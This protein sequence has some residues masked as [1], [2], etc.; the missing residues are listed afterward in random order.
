MRACSCVCVSVYVCMS[1]YICYVCVPRCVS[2]SVF[3]YV[4]IS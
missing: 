4:N 3:V 1:V 2:V